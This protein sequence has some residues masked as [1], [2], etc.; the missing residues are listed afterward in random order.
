MIAVVNLGKD[1]DAIAA[2]IEQIPRAV[3]QADFNN[4]KISQ[5]LV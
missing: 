1:A 4:R 2:M 5:C 3:L